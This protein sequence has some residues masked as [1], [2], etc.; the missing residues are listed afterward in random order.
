MFRKS[1]IIIVLAAAACFC[2]SSQSRIVRDFSPACDS[3]SV[4]ANQRTGVAGQLRLKSVMKRGNLLDFYFTESLGDF[5]WRDE[6]MKWFRNTLKS[7]FPAQ[8]ASSGIGEIYSRGDKMETFATA[9]H[10]SD[11]APA[12]SK[13]R[14]WNVRVPETPAVVR[15][16]RPQFGKG[17]DGR[18]IVLWASHGRYYDQA[19][20]RWQWQRPCLFQTVEDLFT[21]SFTIPFLA[22]ML[23]NAGAYVMMPRERDPNPVEIVID[24]DEAPEKEAKGYRGGEGYSFH[25]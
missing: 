25:R 8:Y 9:R 2:A 5:P 12:S 6:D 10:G 23:E 13:N 11:G 7:L 1:A 21:S 16:G 14:I 19:Q 4:L 24:N 22:P 18:H 3:L 17:L 15:I 20:H